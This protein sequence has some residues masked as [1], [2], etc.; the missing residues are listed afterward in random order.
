M[1]RVRCVVRIIFY[2]FSR[3]NYMSNDE[4]AYIPLIHSLDRMHS[5]YQAAKY[6]PRTS[7][8]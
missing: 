1:A 3:R 4:L 8:S 7:K 5:K 2:C 6:H